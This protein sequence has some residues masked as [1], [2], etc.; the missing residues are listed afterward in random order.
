MSLK[1]CQEQFAHALTRTDFAGASSWVREDA[2]AAERRLWI[3]HNQVHLAWRDALETT[4]PAVL[5]LVGIRYFRNL[6]LRYGRHYLSPS[7][8]LRD[9]GEDFPRFLESR[10]EI[11]RYPYL[12]DVA[13][14]EW[15]RCAVL[16]GVKE[17][18]ALPASLAGFRL[19]QWPHL[20]I[21]LAESLQLLLSPYP[22][23]KLWAAATGT[24]GERQEAKAALAHGEAAAVAVYRDHHQVTVETISPTLWRWLFALR[25]RAELSAAVNI[26][27]DVGSIVNESFDLQGA[28][29]W[30]F[31][32]RLVTGI[33]TAA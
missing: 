25:E 21:Q 12:P 16:S 22:I 17:Q 4:Y 31:A 13:R 29:G 15:A 27:L 30:A 8:N 9:Y 28:L 3:Y 20:R 2:L 33:Q 23:A 11:G 24:R 6:A 14:L 26:A 7:G 10:P 1:E 32:R 19:E 18:M 5:A